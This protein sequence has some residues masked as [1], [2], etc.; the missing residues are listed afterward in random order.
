[1]NEKKDPGALESEWLVVPC[2]HCKREVRIRAE[3][4]RSQLACPYCSKPLGEATDSHRALTPPTSG[5]ISPTNLQRHRK[6]TAKRNPAWDNTHAETQD[7]EHDADTTEFLEIDPNDEN[8]MRI[9]RVR[10]KMHLRP[11]QKVRRIL[12][13]SLL[14]I[15]CTA[16][17]TLFMMLVFKGD[18]TV[19]TDSNTGAIE[20]EAIQ[21]LPLNETPGNDIPG[22]LTRDERNYCLEMI[23][24]FAAA[25]TPEEKLTLVT[26]PEIT[27]ERMKNIAAHSENETYS[28]IIYSN[29]VKLKSG[30]YV[31]LLA[32]RIGNL[33]QQR[34]FAFIQS[35]K[36]N[37]KMHWE[38]SFGYQSMPLEEFRS[39]RP[40]VAQQFRVKLRNGDFYANHYADKDR[41]HCVEIYYPGNPDFLIYGYIDRETP[42]GKEVIAR[43]DPSQDSIPGLPTFEKNLSVISSLR[44]LENSTSDNQVEVVDIKSYSWFE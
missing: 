10:R 15:I 37:I 41:W 28:E 7:P 34:Y 24:A 42:F 38:V 33:D 3:S 21:E 11:W 5:S 23:H 8:Q 43:L 31:I 20:A 19:P 12:F 36:D 17:I 9:R 32:V 16:G 39:N 35:S 25:K 18:K 29:K 1:M 27:A 14:A 44:F 30:N 26:H 2:P 13:F 6:V 40:S 4:R 22:S